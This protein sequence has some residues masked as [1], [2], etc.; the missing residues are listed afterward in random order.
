M[1]VGTWLSN[2]RVATSIGSCFGAGLIP[3]LAYVAFWEWLDPLLYLFAILGTYAVLGGFAVLQ[4]FRAAKMN[5]WK[6]RIGAL[7]VV[8]GF[9]A[10][11]FLGLRPKPD[12]LEP[13]M[14]SC[15][16]GLTVHPVQFALGM[17]VVTASLCFD[18]GDRFN[19]F[20]GE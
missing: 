5:E 7:A 8:V 17:L 9:A 13:A 1:D 19:P 3:L 20:V 10:A 12:C 14:G 4:T 2:H 16:R 18:F 6:R 15:L 11:I